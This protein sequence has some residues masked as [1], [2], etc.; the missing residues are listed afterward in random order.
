MEFIKKNKFTIIAIICFLLLM[1]IAI[2]VKNV[3]FPNGSNAIYGDRLD[4][5]KEVKFTKSNSSKVI[6]AFSD[7][8]A[9]KEVAS[10]LKDVIK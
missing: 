9:V 2:E 1:L 4:G 8:E 10:F 3:F 7:N 6:E 5:I